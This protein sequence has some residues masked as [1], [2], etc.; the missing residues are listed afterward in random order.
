MSNDAMKKQY[1]Y[2]KEKLDILKNSSLFSNVTAILIMYFKHRGLKGYMIN[3]AI[4]FIMISFI[5]WIARP[6]F[7]NRVLLDP[8]LKLEGSFFRIYFD[9]LYIHWFVKIFAII[10]Q[11]G[12]YLYV[13]TIVSIVYEIKKVKERMGG[14]K[15]D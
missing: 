3:S 13:L 15:V 8:G 4:E 10:S 7:E 6:K 5:F 9:W 11:R 2:N 1:L 14:M 12:Y